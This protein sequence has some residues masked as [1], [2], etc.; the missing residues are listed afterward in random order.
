ME[1]DISPESLARQI[2]EL[3]AHIEALK[4]AVLALAATHPDPADL[5]RHYD[6]AAAVLARQEQA[7]TKP[8]AYVQRLTWLLPILRSQIELANPQG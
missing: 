7:S 3:A 2:H 1:T 5:L 8:V 4:A 6:A